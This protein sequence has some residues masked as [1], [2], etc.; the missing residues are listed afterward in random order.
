M[1]KLC[2]RCSKE[3]VCREDRTD[4]CRCTHTYLVPG[5]RDY[6]KDNFDNC[7]CSA[8]MKEISA[9]YN[10]FGINPQ[11]IVKQESKQ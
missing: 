7:L 10:S 1:R 8:C 9:S 5:S 2:D 11:Y 3:F 4:L 6:I